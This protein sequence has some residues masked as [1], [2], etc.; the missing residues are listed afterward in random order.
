MMPVY[1]GLTESK[2][3]HTIALKVV[4]KA[5]VLIKAETCVLKWLLLSC[6]HCSLL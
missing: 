5:S 3:K 4:N 2:A 1:V 6:Y